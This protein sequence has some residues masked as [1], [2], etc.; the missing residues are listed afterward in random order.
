[1]ISAGAK[2]RLGSKTRPPM[3][4]W[5][6]AVLIA[7]AMALPLVYLFLRALEN[8]WAGIFE[9]ALRDRSLAV[10]FRSVALAAVVTAASVT[11][12][13]P[14]AWLTVRTDLPGRRVWVVLAA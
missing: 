12:A 6:P 9:V 14:L 5:V 13:V 11:V 7:A 3:T 8:G 10:L 1:L 4:V 2:P